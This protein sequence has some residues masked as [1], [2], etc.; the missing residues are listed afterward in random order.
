MYDRSERRKD[1]G[2]IPQP[3]RVLAPRYSRDYGNH[4]RAD[5]QPHASTVTCASRPTPTALDRAMLPSLMRWLAQSL[6]CA[7]AGGC[8][9][10]AGAA[11]VL[12]EEVLVRDE[13][14]RGRTDPESPGWK[15]I[16]LL[17]ANPLP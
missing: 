9:S 2:Q 13:T 11:A 16:S 4:A 5:T 3:S 17:R 10:P 7:H 8:V 1:R 14:P 15:R 12:F 6:A